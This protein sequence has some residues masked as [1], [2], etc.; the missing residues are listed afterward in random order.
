MAREII[1]YVT[2]AHGAG[3][4]TIKITHDALDRYRCGGGC[5]ECQLDV[6][7]NFKGTALNGC[8]KTTL[9]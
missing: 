8:S 1:G 9:R 4:S 2:K 5:G 6:H 7:F 3:G